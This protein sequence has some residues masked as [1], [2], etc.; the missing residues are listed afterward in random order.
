L[1]S[2]RALGHAEK[3]NHPIG[4]DEL[5]T[6][7]GVSRPTLE[8]GFRESFDISPQ[9]F[10]RRVRLN[11]L[12]PDLRRA[13]PGQ[14]SVTEAAMH[15]GFVELGRTGVEY[16]QLFGE[17]PSTTLARDGRI[18]CRRY[19]DALAFSASGNGDDPQY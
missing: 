18:D 11:G 14:A 15:W 8:L 1:A 4:V 7:A 10:L 13:K 3:L 17:Y 16:R 5:A 12:H 2:R 19:A 6:A 9:R